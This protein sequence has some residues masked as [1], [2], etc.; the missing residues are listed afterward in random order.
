M[1][2]TGRTRRKGGASGA[3]ERILGVFEM[4]AGYGT[5]RTRTGTSA[6]RTAPRRR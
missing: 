5:K 6:A 3:L 4:F 1:A 2:T